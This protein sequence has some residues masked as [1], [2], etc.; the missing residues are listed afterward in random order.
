MSSLSRIDEKILN[1]KGAIRRSEVPR[2]VVR[3]LEAGLIESKNL[4]ELLALDPIKLFNSVVDDFGFHEAKKM[5]S[6]YKK[7]QQEKIMGK[8]R[9]AAFVLRSLM[10]EREFKRDVPRLSSH[11]S[12]NVRSWMAFLI[13]DLPKVKPFTDLRIFA[14]DSHMSVREC[15]WMALRPHV[16]K[17]FDKA[18]P[19]LKKWAVSSR[20]GSRRAAIETCRPRGVWCTHFDYLKKD[21]QPARP[22]L[23]LVFEDPERYVQNSVANW[24]NDASK[25]H[26]KWV[27]NVCREW[28]RRSTSPATAYIIHRGGRSL[29][30]GV[31]AKRSVFNPSYPDP[32]FNRQ[33]YR[34]NR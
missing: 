23:D 15:A 6:E 31:S 33:E 14:D 21:P 8:M 2:E 28:S 4:T 27:M 30:K 29:R 19:Q 34:E 20:V 12:D 18:L 7:L 13:S 22:L 25:N 32:S 26:P 1:R 17:D 9:G 16:V 24:L 5:K 3:L 11:V 10:T